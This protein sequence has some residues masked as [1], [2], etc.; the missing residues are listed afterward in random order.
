MNCII[1]PPLYSNIATVSLLGWRDRHYIQVSLYST[2]FRAITSKCFVYA[3]TSALIE[4]VDKLYDSIMP[5]ESNPEA[6]IGQILSA[7]DEAFINGSVNIVTELVVDSPA[8]D[9]LVEIDH[10]RHE[11]ECM[12]VHLSTELEKLRAENEQLHKQVRELAQHHTSNHPSLSSPS[13]NHPSVSSPSSNH[14]SVSSTSSNHPS[15]SSP[16]SN[17]PS[18]S[19]P[20]SN[21]PSISS[22]SSNHPSTYSSSS[23]DPVLLPSSS[24]N[25]CQPNLWELEDTV[26]KSF[27][28]LPKDI[29]AFYRQMKEGDEKQKKFSEL[30][31]AF[32]KNK[33]TKGAYS[34]RKAIYTFISQHEGVDSDET[35]FNKHKE[36]SPLQMYEHYI[37]KSRLQSQ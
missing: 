33:R 26:I 16:S 14:P 23:T 28:S 30:P 10:L 24:E 8:P 20:S 15:L 34:K 12:K 31:E 35:F 29:T 36:L 7:I 18:L 4:L 1:R 37:K 21:H 32:K 5:S 19:S 6:T 2:P 13:N 22:P 11:N 9:L 27:N 3:E 17:H 25:Q